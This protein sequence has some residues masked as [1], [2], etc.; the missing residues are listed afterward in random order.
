MCCMAVL[1]TEVDYFAN[2]DM[3]ITY[4]EPTTVVKKIP[5]RALIPL[6]QPEP[7]ASPPSNRY[8]FDS[9]LADDDVICHISHLHQRIVQ[10]M[11][12]D[13]CA[14]DGC[15]EQDTG[16]GSGSGL[17]GGWGAGD[18]DL[19]LDLDLDGNNSGSGTGTG[20]GNRSSAKKTSGRSSNGKKESKVGKKGKGLVAV[21]MVDDS[22][23]DIDV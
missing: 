2:M 14:C 7:V 16:G 10:F 22:S 9:L 20:T 19:D 21:Q 1:S 3:G 6:H 17:G 11:S 4:Q 15:C 18:A 13:T 12:V 5:A 23:L 8:N